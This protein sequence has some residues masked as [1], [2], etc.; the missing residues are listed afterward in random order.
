MP[1]LGCKEGIFGTNTHT[2]AATLFFFSI[3]ELNYYRFNAWKRNLEGD[4]NLKQGE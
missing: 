3:K 4:S 2:L 1:E